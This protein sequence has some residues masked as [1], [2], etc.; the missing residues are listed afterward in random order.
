M[1][2]QFFLLRK[3]PLILASLEAFTETKEPLFK[4]NYT[5]SHAWMEYT[6]T[7]NLMS[8]EASFEEN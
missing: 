4:L 3:Y 2:I 6:C 7:R 5:A 1:L 8:Y